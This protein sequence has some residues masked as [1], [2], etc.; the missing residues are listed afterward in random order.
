MKVH[1][2][3]TGWV[4]IKTA[5]P[6]GHGRGLLRQLAIFA[7][8]NW[9]DWAPTYAWLIDHDEGPIVVDTGQGAHLLEHD[10][11]LHPY[12]RWEV[13]FR[14]EPEEE[15][16]PRLKALGVDPRDVKRVILTHLHMDHDGGLAHFPNSEILVAPK[17]L[18]LARGVMGQLRGYLPNRWPS[19]FDPK[20]LELTAEPAGPFMTSRRM[21]QAG[22]VVVVVAT[23][24]HTANHLSVIAYQ[25]DAA[26]FLAGDASYTQDLMLAGKVD[27]VSPDVAQAAA[28][29][30][31]I[32]Q[33]AVEQPTI[34]LPTHDPQSAVRLAARELVP[35][36]PAPYG[37]DRV[38]ITDLVA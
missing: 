27:G 11:S 12:V 1:A 28:T 37:D 33:F 13:A 26:V 17:E 5:Q 22:D 23:P 38:G 2:I 8:P 29:L 30:A 24:G 21:T 6:E 16:G 35:L 36:G 9:T 19:W 34:Y 4:R 10:R 31:A 18:A 25:D 20:P 3:Q 15:I 14:I 7:D 32:R